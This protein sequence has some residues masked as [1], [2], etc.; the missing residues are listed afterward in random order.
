MPGVI[1]TRVGYTGGTT[2]DPTYHSLG[3]HTEAVQVDFDPTVVSYGDL[4]DVLFGMRNIC[5]PSPNAQY[6]S[7]VFAMNETQRQEAEAKLAEWGAKYSEPVR[8]P[9]LEASTFYLAENYHQKYM[10]KQF[11]ELEQSFARHYTDAR[12]LTDSTAAARVNA[13]AYG[14]GTRAQLEQEIGEY[15]LTAEAEAKL[16][17]LTP[18]AS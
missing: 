5:V 9:V 16:R 6:L 13:F 10:L 8:T 4:L 17:E 2:A 18:A 7:A 12:A 11:D 3:D 1:R 15:G 14:Y